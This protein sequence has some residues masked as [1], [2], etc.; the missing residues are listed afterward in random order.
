MNQVLTIKKPG[1]KVYIWDESGDMYKAVFVADNRKV[2]KFGELNPY[3]IQCRTTHYEDRDKNEWV[4][5]RRVF[6]L[7]QEKEVLTKKEI[8]IKLNQ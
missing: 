5:C 6:K 8:L 3:G 1:Q 2:T 7:L 4:R